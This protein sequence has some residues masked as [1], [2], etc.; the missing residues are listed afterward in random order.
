MNGKT[1][2]W[3]GAGILC[4]FAAAAVA[5]FPAPRSIPALTDFDRYVFVPSGGAPEVTVIDSGDDRIVATI[6]LKAVAGQIVV[7]DAVARLVASNRSGKTLSMV[8]LETRET[9][10][11]IPLEITPDHMQVSPDG[12]LVAVADMDAGSVSIVSLHQRRRLSRIDGLARPYNL[13]FNVDGSM[14]YVANLAADHVS[15]IDVAQGKVIERIAAADASLSPGAAAGP[16]GITNV[17]GTLN[18]QFGFATFRDSNRLAILDL[19]RYRT[20][21]TLAL[22]RE[23]W[24]AYATTDGRYMLVP[25]NGE[26]TVSVI[27]TSSLDVVATLPGAAGVTAVNTGWFDSVAFV[28]SRSENKAVV[29]DLMKLTKASEIPLPDTPGP[30]VVTPDGK[31]LYVALNGSNRVAVIDTR[32][33]K[34]ITMIDDVGVR[35]WGATMGHSNNYCH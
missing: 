27:A 6:P 34:L 30:G 4:V 9:E 28:I 11:V 1:L 15:V 18:G 29:L 17:T 22:G 12:Y 35:P 13:T 33:R 8:D 23:P 16:T 3:S 10:T 20:A 5:W 7:S 24:R 21:K 31:K 26:R 14:I 2:A 32:A 19:D 25:N